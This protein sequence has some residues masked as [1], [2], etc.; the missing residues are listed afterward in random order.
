MKRTPVVS[1]IMGTYNHAPFVTEAIKSVLGQDFADF[2]FLICDDGST[3]ETAAVVAIETDPR[4]KFYPSAINKGAAMV[5]NELIARARGRY[6]A[7]MNSDDAWLPGKLAEQ[8]R[9]LD[10]N[11]KIGAA[12][13]RPQF[14]DRDGILLDDCAL[15]FGKLFHQE[16]RSRG[17]WLRQFFWH[18]NC[19]CHPTV[20]IRR[21]LYDVAGPYD[22]RLRQLPDMDM[23]VRVVKHS[24]IFVSPN[25]LIKFRIL[26]GENTSSDIAPNRIRHW[27]EHF[28]IAQD[29]FKD[30][31]ADLLREGFGRYLTH[32]D[33]PS[34]AHIEIEKALLFLQPVALLT[35]FYRIIAMTKLRALLVDPICRQIL[36]RDYDFDDRS[37]HNLTGEADLL[38]LIATKPEEPVA[39]VQ[40]FMPKRDVSEVSTKMLGRI[41]L[42]RL[43][44][45]LRSRTRLYNR[46]RFR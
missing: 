36:K 40:R 17:E 32:P 30:V 2:E 45:R 35:Q 29:A 20:L 19:L 7:V 43:A 41:I 12:F 3:D 5:L 42:R 26:P 33:L 46:L 11:P 27:N 24:D 23:W 38:H 6:V 28:F 1:V 37:L 22:N 9:L 18:A 25:R 16:N 8:V 44:L 31:S 21:H 39:A 14:V 4:I 10:N 13:G 15:I 34:E